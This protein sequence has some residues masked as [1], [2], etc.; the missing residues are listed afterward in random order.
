MKKL[1]DKF[2]LWLARILQP[3]VERKF[4]LKDTWEL[5]KVENKG[6]KLPYVLF[7]NKS[8]VIN[9]FII[10]VQ[11]IRM[12]F[13][14]FNKSTKAGR[15]LFDGPVKI[16]P[17]SRKSIL[18]EVRLNHITAMFNMLRF[19]FTTNNIQMELKG[20]VQI[21]IL[22]LDFF[23]PVA[24]VMDLP[25][26]KVQMIIDTANNKSTIS[27][28]AFEEVEE[29]LSG[30]DSIKEVSDHQISIKEESLEK[31]LK[32]ELITGKPSSTSEKN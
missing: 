27:N 31:S 14:L 6:V 7:E 13:E 18:M 1:F 8:T 19:V 5:E 11:V 3:L 16:P 9:N 10:P 23:I 29:T 25:K 30:G 4:I 17:R 12:R 21:K 20:E 2:L 24:D 32:E 22:G 26:N 15:I 28:I